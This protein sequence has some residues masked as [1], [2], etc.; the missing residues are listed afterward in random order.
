MNKSKILVQK[1]YFVMRSE[2]QNHRDTEQR[3]CFSLEFS[4]TAQY[5]LPNPTFLLCYICFISRLSPLSF[6][7]VS[8]EEVLYHQDISSF[9]LSKKCKYFFFERE[10]KRHIIEE[11]E[12]KMITLLSLVHVC[13]ICPCIRRN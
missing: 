10:R 2:K 5:T 13:L 1:A 9:P 4:I 7:S 6:E 8:H 11:L 12:Q 3:V